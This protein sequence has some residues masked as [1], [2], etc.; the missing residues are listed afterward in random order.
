[1]IRQKVACCAASGAL[2]L[3]SLTTS[4]QR[5]APKSA[6]KAAR[7]M[8]FAVLNDGTTLEPIAYVDKGRLSEP[9]NGSDDP[10]IIATFNRTYYKPGAVYKLIFGGAESGKVTVKSSN[11]KADCSKNTAAA[12]TKA[13]KTPIKG[14]VMAIATNA[15]AKA[16]AV[17]YRRKPSP[18]EKDEID[19][20]V[21]AEFVRQKLSPKVLHYQNLTALDVENDGK[22][23]LIGSY[24]I[25]VD[26]LTRALLFFIAAKG[27]SGKYS[28]SYK[29][30]K[31]VDQS[32]VMS[33]DIK[34]VDDG[35]YHE[36]LLDAFDYDADGVGEIF[37][38]E[39]GFEGAGFYVYEKKGDKWS[40]VYEF[41]NYHCAF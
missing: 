37:T 16:G 40:R 36:L 20:L 21:K 10:N 11:Y 7:S 9:A 41:S 38:S 12:V 15:A 23:E 2:L 4:A 29:D 13:I 3:S 33:G 8:I 34:A 35:S 25:E 22:P 5:T 17:A 26:K 39:A 31:S 30:Y 27:S 24:W 32:K 28:L 18:A 6:P 1:M 14:L 19:D